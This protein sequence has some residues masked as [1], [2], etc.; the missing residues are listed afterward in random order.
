MAFLLRATKRT[1]QQA[2]TKIR[3]QKI[4]VTRSSN[5]SACFP[6]TELYRG[7]LMAR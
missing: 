6:A 4:V 3:S 1:L 2:L 5:R 7:S